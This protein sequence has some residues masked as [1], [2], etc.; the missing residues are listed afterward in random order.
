MI[1]AQSSR[2]IQFIESLPLWA[3][4]ILALVTLFNLVVF[5]Y[6]VIL[7]LKKLNIPPI[8]PNEL[9]T[10]FSFGKTRYRVFRTER[11]DAPWLVYLHGWGASQFVWRFLT[12]QFTQNFNQITLDIP[13]FGYSQL[14]DPHAEVGIDS[15]C[16]RIVEI[17]DSLQITE[18][19]PIGSS[20]GGAIALWLGCLYPKRIKFVIALN[21]AGSSRLLKLF[22]NIP[23]Q[24]TSQMLKW[25][26]WGLPPFILKL[27]YSRVVSKKTLLGREN[28]EEY[29]I[30]YST[31]PQIFQSLVSSLSLLKDSRLPEGLDQLKC[32]AL[33]LY[34]R[35][36]H[37]IPSWVMTDVIAHIPHAKFFVHAS[38]GH[39]LMEDEP[40][41]VAEHMRHF[42]T[43]N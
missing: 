31:N 18:F 22:P 43:S 41:W 30:P 29:L 34:G 2:L 8:G 38:G 9:E 42:L 19:T 11:Q 5:L 16:R 27:I 4:V 37:I 24:L 7:R 23:T 39:H 10:D 20:M 28:L 13:G 35:G 15:Q 17:L 3:W 33:I 6:L 36:D 26:W 12:P 14:N 40:E 1:S 25:R 32:P 21:P